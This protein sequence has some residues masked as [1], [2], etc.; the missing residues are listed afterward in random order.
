VV[1]TDVP[2]CRD[3]IIAGQTGILVSVR[4]PASLA[5]GIQSLIEDRD[6]CEQ[7]GLAGRELAVNRFSIETV[8]KQHLATYQ[9]LLA[10]PR[11]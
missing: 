5:D 6:K 2:G 10:T 8:I 7:M 1:T 3:A 11:G 9:E 4:D